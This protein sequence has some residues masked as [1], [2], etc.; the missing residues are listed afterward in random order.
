RNTGF[1]CH[2]SSASRR[3]LSKKRAAE[4]RPSSGPPAPIPM[5]ASRWRL[6]LIHAAMIGGSVVVTSSSGALPPSALT[7]SVG[8]STGNREL[9]RRLTALPGRSFSTLSSV[10][11]STS[12]HFP[13]VG[14]S[15]ALDLDGGVIDAEPIVELVL[16][17]G[18]DVVVVAHLW[19][20]HH[21]VR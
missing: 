4:S 9:L 15:L 10:R 18:E 14:V 11:R 5:G 13:E 12:V 1:S 3:T 7:K 20:Q 6:A 16:D 21:Q 19:I 2:V 8:L 17:R